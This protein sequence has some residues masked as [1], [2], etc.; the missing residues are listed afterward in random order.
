[1]DAL[2]GRDSFVGEQVVPKALARVVPA[3]G[4]RGHVLREILTALDLESDLGEQ[5]L[6]DR[7]GGED[8]D[9]HRASVRDL[10]LGDESGDDRRVGEEDPGSRTWSRGATPEGSRGDPA[11][12]TSRR[13]RRR[14]RSSHPRM[15]AGFR[16]RPG[17]SVL[18]PQQPSSSA[19]R[20][21]V[22]M[23]SSTRSIPTTLGPGP[24]DQAQSRPA[25]ATAHVE[26]PRVGAEPEPV[27]ETVELVGGHPTRLPEVVPVRQQPDLLSNAVAGVRRRVER[28]SVRPRV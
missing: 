18:D 11:G 14:C 9:P 5:R 25:R 28:D 3:A 22:A 17:R 7:L 10:A 12:G 8:V 1:M 26:Q 23:P 20:V 19:S 4:H 13:S 15:E 6:V 21:A 27:R 16:H 24:L 2:E